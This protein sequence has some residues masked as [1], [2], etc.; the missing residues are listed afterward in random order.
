MSARAPKQKSAFAVD[1]GAAID[2]SG[3]AT[4]GGVQLP[5]NV[6][7]FAGDSITR[8]GAAGWPTETWSTGY[9]TWAQT[10]FVNAVTTKQSLNFGV[11]GETSAQVAARAA[12]N[13]AAAKAAGATFIVELSGINSITAGVGWA[14]I[15]ASRQAA[16]SAYRAAGLRVIAGTILP[17]QFYTGSTPLSASMARNLCAVNQW[18]RENLSALGVEIWDGFFT[19]FDPASATAGALSGYTTDGKH[20]TQTW[21]YWLGKSL[22]AVYARVF[23]AVGVL[24]VAGLG[25]SYSA[26]D[27]P[28]GN[29]LVNA[30]LAG[31][32]GTNVGAYATGS[33]ADNWAV[34]RLSG[35][36]IVAVST[37]VTIPLPNGGTMPAQQIVF[38][39]PGAGAAHEQITFKQNV[40]GFAVGEAAYSAFDIAVSAPT[41]AAQIYSNT[42]M[43]YGG[44]SSTSGNNYFGANFI[45]EGYSGS[46]ITPPLTTLAGGSTVAAGLIVDL[47]CTSAASVTVVISNPS[48]RK[49]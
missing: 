10:L 13:A 4:S 11:D 39:S 48:L 7:A 21:S 31:T 30:T 49:A 35:S 6:G 12:A 23:P 17:C 8:Q 42:Q 37:K 14:S 38:S 44:F 2:S 28:K 20:P 3:L 34:Q 45:P 32:G 18:M 36:T 41:R 26:V 25:D 43:Q 46:P 1:T 19:G 47:D 24:K 27:N 16:W 40:S 5:G 33:V 15:V 9:Q 22:A 29:L